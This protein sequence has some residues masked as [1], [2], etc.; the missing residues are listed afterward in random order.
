M[1]VTENLKTDPGGPARNALTLCAL[2]L[3]HLQA[4][5]RAGF[6]AEEGCNRAHRVAP[7]P[8][9]QAGGRSSSTVTF[10]RPGTYALV[11]S[12]DSHCQLG[13]FQVYTV[14]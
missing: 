5:P 10:S 2:C 13:Q 8:V 12:V 11:C 14:S 6:T 7:L 4:V 9:A 1:G 3:G